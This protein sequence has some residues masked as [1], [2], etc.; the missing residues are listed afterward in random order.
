MQKKVAGGWS[1]V[2]YNLGGIPLQERGFRTEAE[3]DA[4]RLH[5]YALI[6]QE[7]EK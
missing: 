1:V 3:A 2:T 6:R 7:E 4:W 5:Q